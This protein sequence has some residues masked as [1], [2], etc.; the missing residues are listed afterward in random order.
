MR[1]EKMRVVFK[2]NFKTRG[3]MAGLIGWL[4]LSL[5]VVGCAD[6]TPTA[7]P[8]PTPL[9]TPTVAPTATAATSADEIIYDFQPEVPTSQQQQIKRGIDLAIK[10]FGKAG[11]IRVF[12]QDNHIQ[13]Y[14]KAND[15]PLGSAI[16][17]EISI[18]T[19][20]QQGLRQSQ[21]ELLITT[22]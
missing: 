13:L 15:D 12:G 7:P 1:E 2:L 5:L 10:T 14:K 19:A 22:F 6:T 8:S 4:M 17:G 3:R 18:N 16:P 9:P 21:T 20:D 11:S